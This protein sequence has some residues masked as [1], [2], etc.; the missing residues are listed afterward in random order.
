M[1]KREITFKEFITELDHWMQQGFSFSLSLRKMDLTPYTYSTQ[2]KTDENK[3]IEALKKHY[4]D[5]GRRL[6]L[7]ADLPRFDLTQVSMS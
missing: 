7:D 3:I 5:H 1:A 6:P 2:F 4:R